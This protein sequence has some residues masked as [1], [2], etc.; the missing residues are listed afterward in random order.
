MR[1]RPGST[2][3]WESEDQEH[4]RGS[5]WDAFYDSPDEVFRALPEMLRQS[6]PLKTFGD[7]YSGPHEIPEWWANGAYLAWPNG[8]CGLIATFQATEERTELT[9]VSPLAEYGVRGGIEIERVHVW[10]VAQKPRLKAS[11]AVRQYRSSISL[12]S[13]TVLGTSPVSASSLSS[14]GSPTKPNLPPWSPWS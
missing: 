1:L 11:G 14:Q 3:E 4:Y 12:S 10:S 9:N 7:T 8:N 6:M 2:F 13:A 5:H